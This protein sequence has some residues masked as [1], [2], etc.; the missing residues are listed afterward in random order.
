MASLNGNSACYQGGEG[1]TERCEVVRGE[2]GFS[3]ASS[4]LLA[5]GENVTLAI[6]FKAG[7]FAA[8]QPTAEE[9]FWEAAFIVWGIV[10][11]LSS[12]AA[13][14]VVIW[15]SIFW[16]RTKKRVKGRGTIV[17]EYL[18]PKQASVL[19]A[20]QV[21]KMTS[22]ALTAQ[23][24]DLA[25]RHYIK[26]YQT[27]EKKLFQS[28]EYELELIKSDEGLTKEEAQLLSDLFGKHHTVGSRFAMKTMQANY[29]M[30]RQLAQHAKNLSDRMRGGYGYF[31]KAV[32]EAR[33]LKVVATACLIV[34][35][36]GL[37][38]LM[39][40]AA[41]VGY[42]CAYTLWPLTKK[43]V[44]LREYL[45]GLRLYIEVGETERI[46][47]LQSP[48]GAEKVGKVGDDHGVL[49]KLYERV[50]PYAV[51]F[52]VEKDWIKQMGAYYQESSV[53]PD[54]YSGANGAVFNAALFSSTFGSFTEQTS[55]Y[56]SS[57]SSSSGGSSGGGFS[58]GG[59]GGGGGG[60]W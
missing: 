46:K 37:S 59:G 17:P 34:G 2:Q 38:P 47:M 32:P 19:A 60:G 55:T 49:V 9:R 44:I 22:R 16:H 58:G 57:T 45:E 1:S 13:I 11:A 5:A 10:V 24:I 4:R 43:G 35:I 51:L 40:I 21:M 42:S 30:G 25:V 15:M 31:E 28:A 26:I 56:S 33:R 54:W 41:I 6:G 29:S 27:K 3:F 48:D 18:P 52:G 8:Y 36:I 20:S 14:C 7:T 53:Q 50:L 12:I 23:I 39:I